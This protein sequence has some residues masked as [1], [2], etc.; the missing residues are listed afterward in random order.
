MNFAAPWAGALH[1]AVVCSAT[2]P[3]QHGDTFMPTLIVVRHGPTVYSQQNRF[4]GWVDTPLTVK[5]QNDARR[6]GES[7]RRAGLEFDVCFTS[8]LLRAEQT[9]GS[10]RAS[11]PIGDGRIERDWRLNERH[12]GV[13]QGETRGAIIARYGNAQVVEW[14]R[15][16]D[17]CPPL[18]GDD[19]PRRLEQ[20]ARFPD[21]PSH[22]QPRGER[23]RDAAERVAPM[24]HERIVPALAQGMRVLVVAHTSSARGLARL[25]EG[26]TDEQCAAFRI[27]TAIPRIYELDRHLI[28]ERIT[29]LTN[30]ARSQ[31]LYWVN[32]L[33]PR[34]LGAI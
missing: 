12:Y 6:A 26:L 24:W 29:D 16:Y 13:L 30:G 5:G 14:R 20:L 15:A 31:V 1:A 9:L 7:L 28:V 34:R 22:V 21:V 32:R 33:K 19:D 10:I 23:L 25:I 4:A 18:L 3:A 11:V 8:R 27:A 17:A 2:R